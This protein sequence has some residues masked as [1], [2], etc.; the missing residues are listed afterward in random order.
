MTLRNTAVWMDIIFYLKVFV[1]RL[2]YSEK[3]AYFYSFLF[4]CHLLTIWLCRK[5]FGQTRWSLLYVQSRPRFDNEPRN[6]L[7]VS[8]YRYAWTHKN[9]SLRRGSGRFFSQAWY[10]WRRWTGSSDNSDV[11]CRQFVFFLS[12]IYS[13][14]SLEN[15]LWY[16]G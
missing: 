3:T 12:N 14:H 15:F 11:F 10:L 9:A 5:W 1:I 16:S 13:L 8:F 2:Q 6:G 4:R 7:R